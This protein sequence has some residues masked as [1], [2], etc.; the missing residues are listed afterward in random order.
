MNLIRNSIAEDPAN[1]QVIQQYSLNR[2]SRKD[3]SGDACLQGLETDIAQYIPQIASDCDSARL[4]GSCNKE[5]RD[6]LQ[7]F[8]DTRGC[9]V[10]TLYN[11]TYTLVAALNFTV[12]FFQ[13]G[14]LLDLCGVDAPPLTC[15]S[16]P[17]NCFILMMLLPLI[18]TLLGNN[19]IV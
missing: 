10:N 17:L 9:R 5:C 19:Y 14:V 7:N 15:A 2:C 6:T 4:N 11:S 8:I 18:V 13:D 12:P 1:C 16:L 3:G